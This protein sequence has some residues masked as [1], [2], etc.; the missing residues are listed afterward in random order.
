MQKLKAPF[1]LSAKA[2][3]ADNN[4]RIINYHIRFIERYALEG[5]DGEIGV[6]GAMSSVFVKD[7]IDFV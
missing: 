1:A 5:A 7:V 4:H 3:F 2:Y 6:I